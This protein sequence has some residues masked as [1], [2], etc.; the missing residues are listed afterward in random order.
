MISL[1]KNTCYSLY[2][3]LFFL[4]I[5]FC[6]FACSN[7]GPTNPGNQNPLSD[8]ITVGTETQE[9]NQD[10]GTGGGTIIISNTGSVLNGMEIIVPKQGYNENRP[11]TISSSP[12]IEHKLGEYFTP[13]SPMITINNGGGYSE[14]PITIKVPVEKNNDDFIMGFLFN[15]I[16]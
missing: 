4:L 2:R 8:K 13:A 6:L 1:N 3:Y 12:I 15:E 7:D 9:I 16:T 14:Q 11:Y 5:I 10:I